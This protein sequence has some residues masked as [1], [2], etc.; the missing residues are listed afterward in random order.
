MTAVN[1]EVAIAPGC[2]RAYLNLAGP[3]RP[4]PAEVDG[5]LSIERFQRLGALVLGLDHAIARLILRIDRLR[6]TNVRDGS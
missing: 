1:F 6:A 4:V 3:L 5:F 2:Q